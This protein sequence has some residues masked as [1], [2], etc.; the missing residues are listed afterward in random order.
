LRKYEL[1]WLIK[2]KWWDSYR[3]NSTPNPSVYMSIMSWNVIQLNVP[4]KKRLLWK[5]ISREEEE[6]IMLRET[7]CDK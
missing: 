5:R 7:K 1:F 6:I 3:S 2:E 4:S